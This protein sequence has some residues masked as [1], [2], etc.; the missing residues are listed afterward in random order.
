MNPMS[1][2]R[3]REGHSTSGAKSDAADANLLV[4]IVRLDRTR[5]RS[6]SARPAGR[7]GG[8]VT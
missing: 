2:A 8:L 4:E 1:V 3:Y 5:R 7:C 6:A